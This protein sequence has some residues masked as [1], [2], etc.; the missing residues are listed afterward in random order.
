[1]YMVPLKLHKTIT[2]TL[3]MYPQNVFLF[4]LCASLMQFVPERGIPCYSSGIVN[5]L[6]MRP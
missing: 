6:D 1:M 4:I 2:I 5:P 3:V